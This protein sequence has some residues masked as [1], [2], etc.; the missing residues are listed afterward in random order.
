[1]KTDCIGQVMLLVSMIQVF[2]IFILNYVRSPP[3]VIGERSGQ[4]LKLLKW[5]DKTDS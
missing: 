3:T 5:Q 4:Y 2:V 1:M